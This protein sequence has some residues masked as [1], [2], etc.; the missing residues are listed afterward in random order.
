MSVSSPPRPLAA[1]LRAVGGVP[2]TV[3]ELSRELGSTPEAIGGMLVTLRAGG[4]VQEA[5][6]GQGACACTGCSLKSLC[7]N[8]EDAAPQL[9][10]LRLT[11]RGEAYLQ[12]MG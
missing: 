1:L 3:A 6:Q 10:L 8:A 4:Y 2:R 12:R 7:R 11:P 5:Q 9:G